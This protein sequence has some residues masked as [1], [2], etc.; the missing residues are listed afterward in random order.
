MTRKVGHTLRAVHPPCSV[1]DILYF[2]VEWD[3]S[4]IEPRA[5]K[6]AKNPMSDG[7]AS[8]IPTLH[9]EN[10]ECMIIETYAADEKKDIYHE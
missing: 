5:S 10:S 3:M 2:R 7:G 1:K 9:K 4:H 6:F 8:R